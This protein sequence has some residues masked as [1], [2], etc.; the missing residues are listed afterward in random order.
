MFSTSDDNVVLNQIVATHAPDGRDIDVKPLLLVIK[1]IFHLATS[2][3]PGEAQISCKCYGIGDAYGTTLAVF[4][5]LSSYSWDAK[6][7][8]ALAAFSVSYGEFWLVAQLYLSNPLAKSVA[9]LKQLPEIMER[10][11]YLKPKY[12]AITNL[13][14]AMLNVTS[15]IVDFKELPAQYITHGTPAYDKTNVLIP[16]A[17][18]WTIRS[19]VACASQIIGLICM[20]NE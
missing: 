18:Y 2:I 1:D 4:N 5:T 17:A 19:V 14:R 13:V 12:E 6:V 11:D 20:S 16:T 3:I 10:F 15:C 9:I 8:Q 7:V